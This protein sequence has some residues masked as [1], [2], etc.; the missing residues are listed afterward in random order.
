M[1][2]VYTEKEMNPQYE[3]V[4][5]DWQVNPNLPDALFTFSIPL[6]AQRV[7][8]MPMAMTHKK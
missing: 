3:A 6:K 2:I 4:L 7:K 8:L 5:T 1:V